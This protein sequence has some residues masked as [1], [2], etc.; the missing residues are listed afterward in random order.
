[1]SGALP[2]RQGL[3]QAKTG[4]GTPEG[5]E[6]HLPNVGFGSETEVQRSP[7]ERPLP[8]AKPTKS[9]K[10]GRRARTSAFRPRADILTAG[11]EGP[12][13]AISGHR[14][15]TVRSPKSSEIGCAEIPLEPVQISLGIMR[16]S[17]WPQRG[18]R[19]G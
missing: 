17:G 13:V 14:A 4:I 10:S 8:D 9:V 15:T 5:G 18:T 1:M 12:L 19:I 16:I 2:W 6:P 11:S 7:R 3:L